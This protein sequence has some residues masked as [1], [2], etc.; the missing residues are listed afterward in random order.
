MERGPVDG[1]VGL[2]IS[3]IRGI[4]QAGNHVG[5]GDHDDEQDLRILRD[6]E[7]AELDRIGGQR[8]R[9]PRRMVLED[10]PAWG[11]NQLNSAGLERRV[12]KTQRSDQVVCVC[13]DDF[14]CV[15]RR[16]VEREVADVESLR[17]ACGVRS[18]VQP[19]AYSIAEV[20]A[21]L[22]GRGEQTP[23]PGRTEMAVA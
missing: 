5:R 22:E 1:G 9:G 19:E 11:A 10:L 20:A 23:G 17:A 14:A 6:V 12:R 21:R 4:L 15:R 2:S 3:V 13:L 8:G 16:R 18:E 7:G